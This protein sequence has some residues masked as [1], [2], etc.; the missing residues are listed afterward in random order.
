VA[1]TTRMTGLPGGPRREV[2][3]HNFR[4]GTSS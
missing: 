1:D 4:E 3:T 2:I